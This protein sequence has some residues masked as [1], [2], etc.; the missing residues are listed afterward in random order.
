MECSQCHTMN[1]DYYNFCMKCGAP[2]SAPPV[3]PESSAPESA[4]PQEAEPLPPVIP[5]PV[6]PPP[7]SAPP[8]NQPSGYPQGSQPG[9]FPQQASY[10]QP[11]VYPQQG[12]GPTNTYPPANYQQPPYQPPYQQPAQPAWSQYPPMG[13]QM[14]PAQPQSPYY[15][16]Q[17]APLNMAPGGYGHVTM[18]NSLTGGGSLWGPFA[19]YGERRRHVGWLMDSKGDCAEKLVIKVSEKFKERQI[20]NTS[21]RQELL[22]GQGIVVEKRPYFIM[23]RGLASL[24]LYITQFGKDLYVSLASF[25]KPP[26]SNVRVIVLIVSVVFFLFTTFGLPAAIAASLSSLGGMSMFGG[27]PDFSGL[28]TLLCLVGPLGT[29]NSLA[30]G[31]F[32]IYSIWKYLSI[33]DF[34]AGLRATPTEFNEDDLMAME[35]AVEQT[36]RIALDEIGLNPDDLNKVI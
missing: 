1:E 3:A 20:P 24:G 22:S 11:G 34:W 8:G 10:P 33:K 4:A 17:Q 19:G 23:R 13:G 18:P 15:P 9:A 28:I 16:P 5:L 29:I 27:M 35:K 25:L 6:N 31:I 36:V 32:L 14:Q 21:L 7:V 12:G 30:L 2:L 26:I